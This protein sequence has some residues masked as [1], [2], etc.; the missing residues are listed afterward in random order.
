MPENIFPENAKG[1]YTFATLQ[2]KMPFHH[3]FFKAMDENF[4]SLIE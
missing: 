3:P 2:D 1:A 4:K